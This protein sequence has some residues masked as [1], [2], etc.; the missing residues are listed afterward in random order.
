M[1]KR[2]KKK[3]RIQ[4]EGKNRRREERTGEIEAKMSSRI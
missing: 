1:K 4:L 3:V 2:S